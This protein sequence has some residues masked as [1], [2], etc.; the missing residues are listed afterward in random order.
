MLRSDAATVAVL[1]NII[2]FM[3]LSHALCVDQ[4]DSREN[5]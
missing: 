4:L 2:F 3:F 1:K 5:V